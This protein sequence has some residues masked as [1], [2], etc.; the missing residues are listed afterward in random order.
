MVFPDHRRLLP[1]DVIL[2]VAAGIARNAGQMA[3][4]LAVSSEA[5][6]L[7]RP[8]V[9]Y[10]TSGMFSDLTGPNHVV[11][12]RSRVEVGRRGVLAGL[13]GAAA[14]SLAGCTTIAGQTPGKARLGLADITAMR[15]LMRDY[16]GTLRRVAELGYTTM[17]F[18]LHGYGGQEAGEPLPLDKARMVREA[19]LEV[20]VV[21]LGVRNVDYDRELDQA[22]AT[23]ARIVAMTTAPPFIAGP[24]LY[25]TTRAAFDAWLPQLAA[26]GEQA[27]SRGLALAYHNHWYDLAPL[28]GEAPLDLIARQIAPDVV[29]FEIDLAWTWYAGVDPLELLGRL[30]P[31]VVSMHLKDIDRSRGTSIT[32][33]AVAPGQGEMNYPALLPHIRRLTSATGYVEVDKPDDGLAA[34]AAGA[35]VFRL[36]MA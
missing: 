13:A 10:G 1:G 35:R 25:E 14:S 30:G 9:S 34:A 18:R 6:R 21:R 7:R 11:S 22:A 36:A 19:G 31:R 33:H 23:G 27:K 12:A 28:G 26:I 3:A 15:E 24:R 29:A 17:G 16:A 32:D 5:D 8:P 20:G 4:T 2:E